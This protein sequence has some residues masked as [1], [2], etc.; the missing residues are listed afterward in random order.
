MPSRLKGANRPDDPE[1]RELRHLCS[2]RSPLGTALANLSV[3]TTLL[4][5]G[6]SI[7]SDQVDHFGLPGLLHFVYDLSRP[8]LN[9]ETSN[10]PVGKFRS[11]NCDNR[12]GCS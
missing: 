8:E 4:D 6:I 7:G 11:F 10:F 2:D 9:P 3:P 1:V 12:S 5:H